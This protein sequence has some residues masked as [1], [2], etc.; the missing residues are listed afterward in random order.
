[1]D[2]H[3]ESI[4]RDRY[5]GFVSYCRSI[6]EQRMLEDQNHFNYNIALKHLEHFTG[7]EISFET[8]TSDWLRKF[9]EF[10]KTTN[11]LRCEKPLSMNSASTY[12]NIIHSMA[13]HAA[14]GQ[15]IDHCVINNPP[16]NKRV[17]ASPNYL[18]IVELNK[19]AST[20]CNH[21][22]L[23][24]AFLFS[25][26]T[27]LGWKEIESLKWRDV[28]LA[29]GSWHI[30]T[31]NISVPLNGQAMLLLGELGNPEC[32]IFNLHYSAALCANLNKWALHA[33][34]LRQITFSSAK[35]SFAMALLNQGVS[36]EL[37]S[38]LLGHRHVKST[39]KL[40]QS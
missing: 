39:I 10:L 36:I 19:L 33:G 23:K 28:A 21:P 13:R 25:C 9:N 18:S 16:I 20:P 38:E 8:V 29:N 31:T 24:N 40:L 34:I 4:Q 3:S 37:I 6:L 17:K 14:N 5:A 12:F 7:G 30:R 27:G 1:M 35:L 32:N 22:R 11:G 2:K 26:L 15:R